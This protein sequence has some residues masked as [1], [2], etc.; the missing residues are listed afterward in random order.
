MESYE[1]LLMDYVKWFVACNLDN[2]SLGKN[3]QNCHCQLSC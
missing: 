1:I 3:D 2:C